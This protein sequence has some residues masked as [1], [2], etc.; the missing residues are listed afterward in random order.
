MRV[1]GRALALLLA[2]V[3]FAGLTWALWPEASDEDRV[4]A[5]IAAVVDAAEEGD[6]GAVMEQVDPGY[7]AVEGGEG[8]EG[9]DAETLRAALTYQFLRRG[10][11][12]VVLSPVEVRLDGDRARASFDAA[13]A[14]TGGWGGMVPVDADGWHLEVDLRR[15][16]DERWRVSGHTR[17]S[18]T[19][20]VNPGP[21]PR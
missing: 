4:R 13:V 14:E 12:V 20:P 16:Q 7:R 11:V 17:S 10:P 21:L 2:L 8:E 15:G 6:V 18:W 1:S 3:G 19:R 5:V 9:V